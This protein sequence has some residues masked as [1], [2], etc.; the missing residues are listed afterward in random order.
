MIAFLLLCGL[1]VAA[2]VVLSLV[3]LPLFAIGGVFWLITFPIRILFKLLF[4]LGGALLGLVLAPVIAVVV[5]IVVA[6]ALVGAVLSLLAPLVP[7][8]LLGFF[9]W[10]VYRLTSRD[11]AAA[12]PTP[13]RWS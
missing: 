10:A 3:A 11:H 12:P 1:A 13:D 6:V 4:G 8:V 9:A 5:A 7:M 2:C